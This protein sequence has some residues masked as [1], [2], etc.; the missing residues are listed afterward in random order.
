M[1]EKLGVDPATLLGWEAGRH[2]PTEKSLD[3]IERVLRL[4]NGGELGEWQFSGGPIILKLPRPWM[5]RHFSRLIFESEPVHIPRC[6]YCDT[7]GWRTSMEVAG[8]NGGL[9]NI[10]RLDS[11]C[12]DVNHAV[13]ILNRA[14]DL[15][16][17]TA[18]HP[19]PLPLE[20]V[21][22][23]DD[24]GDSRLILKREKNKPLGR[25][26]PLSGNDSASHGHGLVIARTS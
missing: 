1:A 7:L 10:E 2:Q 22:G 12:F 11:L 25:A 17:P 15:K 19:Y 8:A 18:R 9:R 3:V 26:G 24:I 21:R 20:N 5:L 14:S 6:G 23:Y 4:C 13:L 16:K